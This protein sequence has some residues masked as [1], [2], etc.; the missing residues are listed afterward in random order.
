MLIVIVNA[1][2][3]MELLME[4]LKQRQPA[5]LTHLPARTFRLNCGS[6]GFSILSLIPTHRLEP[7]PACCHLPRYQHS[8]SLGQGRAVEDQDLRGRPTQP[9]EL[10]VSP[11]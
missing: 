5:T 1:V 11:Q 10:A 9:P 8:S 3:R 6:K 4:L 7:D 2:S